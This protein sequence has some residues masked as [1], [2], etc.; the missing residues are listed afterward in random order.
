VVMDVVMIAV[1][2]QPRMGSKQAHEVPHPARALGLT[3]PST[4]VCED[5]RVNGVDAGPGV[6]LEGSK[7]CVPGLGHQQRQG[8]TCSARWVIAACHARAVPLRNCGD[9]SRTG[10][11]HVNLAVAT[12][13]RPWRRRPHHLLLP[14]LGGPCPSIR[15]TES[16]SDHATNSQ[17]GHHADATLSVGLACE[18]C[19]QAA[20][21]GERGQ[22]G[23]LHRQGHRQPFHWSWLRQR[24]GGETS[25]DRSPRW[26]A[27]RGG[28][29]AR[30][31]NR[32]LMPGTPPRPASDVI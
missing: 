8:H 1:I 23:W 30:C 2:P 25:L 31:F 6:S 14:T 5:Q 12:P 21:D 24:R 26:W 3:S 29:P 11:P 10:V 4:V 16:S 7:G 13:P 32:V 20:R 17:N 22:R 28:V 27:I 15:T 9:L 19:W 18:P